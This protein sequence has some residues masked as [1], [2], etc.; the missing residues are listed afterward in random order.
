MTRATP[1]RHPGVHVPPPIIYAAGF[2]A[3][4]L[5]QRWRP[6]PITAGTSFVREA[7]ALACFVVWMALMFWAMATFR[8]ART[9]IL[10]IR[11]ASR[12][13]TGGPYRFTR[14]PMYLSLVMLYLGLTLAI[15]SIWPALLLPLV[16][17]VIDRAVI[18]REERYL[19]EAFPGDY[20]TYRQRVRRWL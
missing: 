7:A 18:Q 14:N 5:L 6:L 19:G 4:W 11:P 20:S 3:G 9:A 10:P 15:N 8:R 1:R 2:L 12:I 13:V 17:L 16:V